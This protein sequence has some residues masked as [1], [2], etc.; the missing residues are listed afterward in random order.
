MYEAYYQLTADPFRLTPDHRFCYSNGDDKRALLNLKYTL[1][2]GEGFIM[3]TGSPG[4]GKTTLVNDLLASTNTQRTVAKLES[5]RL[6]VEN[7]LQEIASSFGL[8]ASSGRD[9]AKLYQRLKEFLMKQNTTNNKALLLLREAHTLSLETLE[10]IR[11]LGILHAAG[12]PLLQ[13]VL[14]GQSGLVK[15]VHSVGM[16]QLSQRILAAY[17]VPPLA[18][19]DTPAYIA[20]RLQ[21]AGWKGDPQLGD[22]LYPVIYELSRGVPR[23][24]NKLCRQ[25]FLYGCLHK[26]HA[27]GMDDLYTTISAIHEEEGA[28]PRRT[29]LPPAS[30]PKAKAPLAGISRHEASHVLPPALA[31]ADTDPALLS[32]TEG[33]GGSLHANLEGTVLNCRFRLV[34]RIA[35]GAISTV[36]KALDLRRVEVE[37]ESPYVAIKV[38]NKK[39]SKHGDWLIALHQV[40]HQFIEFKHPNTAKVYDLDRDDNLVY[41]VMEYVSGCSLRKRIDEPNFNGMSIKETLRIANSIGNAI[42]FIHRSGMR[43]GDLKPENII[44]ADTGEIKV[45]DFGISRSIERVITALSQSRT[46]KSF[47]PQY[48]SPEKLENR[49]LDKRDD[50]YAFA[51]TFYEILTGRHPFNELTATLAQAK[52]LQPEKPVSLNHRQWKALEKALEFD[53]NK[54][55][56]SMVELLAKL[57]PKRSLHQPKR[58]QG[59]TSIVFPISPKPSSDA[60]EPPNTYPPTLVSK[61]QL[62]IGTAAL[63]GFLGGFLGFIVGSYWLIPSSY[64]TILPSLEQHVYERVIDPPIARM[65]SNKIP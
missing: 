47:T 46:A 37:N 35:S 61:Q 54:R 21:T 10:E 22:E 24:I 32:P 60:L 30:F 45:I 39:F 65:E 59:L 41:L 43:H 18:A 33:A 55:T 14:M 40:A 36:Y 3:I 44:I 28:P 6:K 48:A 16:E 15:R 42:A 19:E 20:H 62:V 1:H 5:A 12:E 23:Q 53:R 50:I 13:L 63:A 52:K 26:K 51:C 49:Y 2:S 9:R 7:V 57:N 64:E 56:S 38:L 11:L 34:K 8:D 17:E 58:T 27:L 29:T 25:L 4:V 31:V